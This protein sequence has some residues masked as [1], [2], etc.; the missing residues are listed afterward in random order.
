MK[1]VAMTFGLACLLCA[2]T[3]CQKD[4]DRADS[5]KGYDLV[6]EID[7]SEPVL[8]GKH[9]LGRSVPSPAPGMEYRSQTLALTPAQIQKLRMHNHVEFVGEMDVN[10]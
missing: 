5:G 9:T 2:L 7:I 6:G 10:Y 3:G 8:A 4:E 1:K